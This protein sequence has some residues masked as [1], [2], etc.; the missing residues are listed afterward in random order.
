MNR[1][2]VA[3]FAVGLLSGCSKI[4]TVKQNMIGQD[5]EAYY[6]VKTQVVCF[7]TTSSAGDHVFCLPAKQV[8]T[9]ELTPGGWRVV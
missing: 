1:L 7:T 6:S 5:L 4:S 3:I 9:N 2:F 8:D